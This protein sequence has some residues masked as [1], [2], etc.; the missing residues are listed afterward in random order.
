[1]SNDKKTD[2]PIPKR[3]YPQSIIDKLP[4]VQPMPITEKTKSIFE[5]V[6]TEKT[7]DMKNIDT[8]RDAIIR[9]LKDGGKPLGTTKCPICGGVLMYNQA[10]NLHIHARC[11]DCDI[12]WME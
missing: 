12:A 4:S 10:Y 7:E 8:C 2:F 5:M 9:H 6:V 11:K 3:P 1:M